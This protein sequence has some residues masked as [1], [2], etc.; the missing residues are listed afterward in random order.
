MLIGA[1]ISVAQGYSKAVDYA[2]EVGCECVQIFAK[3]PRQWRGPAVDP[4]AAATF[5]QLRTERGVGPLFTHTAYLL[6]L[7]TD[8]DVLWEKSVDA[9]A[10]ELA[11]GSL[12]CAEG[13]VTHI[14]ND[15]TSDPERVAD[16]VAQAVVRALDRVGR[17]HCRTR[18]LLENTAGAGTS[19]GTSPSELA[20]I[21]QSAGVASERLGVCLDTC[22]AHAFGFDLSTA[23]G[24]DDLVSEIAAHVGIERLGLLHANDCKF[25][26]GSKRDRH[27]WIGDG[28]IGTEGFTAMLCHPALSNVCVV[29]E[30]PGEVPV[31]DVE[32]LRRLKDLRSSC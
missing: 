14:G 19:V 31:K 22:H 32:N 7:S 25:E 3:S 5:R 24:W 13:V 15:K 2:A 18:L 16:R 9:L 17:S 26:S 6:N 10:D 28:T 20:P 30:M 11:R 29:T 8:D 23:A 27:E 1:H 21:I 12:L 4:G